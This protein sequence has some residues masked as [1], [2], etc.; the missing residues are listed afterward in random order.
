[1]AQQ[2]AAQQVAGLLS[3]VARWSVLLGVGGSA[4]QAS[5][6]TGTVT[7]A[8]KPRRVGVVSRS[9]LHAHSTTKL[10]S[11]LSSIPRDR[12]CAKS[13]DLVAGGN[14]FSDC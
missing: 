6:Y 7:P 14:L 10:W 3:R 9:F 4:L 8:D 13:L 2:Q 1:M 12:T 5:L 11:V